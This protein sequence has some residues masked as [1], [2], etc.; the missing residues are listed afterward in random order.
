MLCLLYPSAYLSVKVEGGGVGRYGW[1]G[2]DAKAEPSEAEF[3]SLCSRERRP[4][5]SQGGRTEPRSR[6]CI[7]L[8]L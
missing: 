3:L 8:H 5:G 4:R 1:Y 2:R 7:Q 6:P